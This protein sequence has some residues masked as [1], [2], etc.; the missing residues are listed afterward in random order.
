MKKAA[1]A[2]LATLILAGSISPL[3]PILRDGNPPPQCPPSKPNCNG[4]VPVSS[5]PDLAF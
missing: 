4:V 2:M 3:N 1:L 5:S